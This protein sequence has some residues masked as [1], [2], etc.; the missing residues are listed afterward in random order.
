MMDSFGLTDGPAIDED[1][2]VIHLGHLSESQYDAVVKSVIE[3]MNRRWPNL[4]Q[5]GVDS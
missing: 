1:T 4:M 5:L 2:I 3:F